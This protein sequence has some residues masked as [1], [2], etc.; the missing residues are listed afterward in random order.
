MADSDGD[1]DAPCVLSDSESSDEGYY[2]LSEFE[3]DDPARERAAFENIDAAIEALAVERGLPPVP[4]NK[5]DG[6]EMDGNG[7][8]D[9]EETHAQ[10][11]KR[12]RIMSKRSERKSTARESRS[13]AEEIPKKVHGSGKS[14]ARGARCG[15]TASQVRQLMHF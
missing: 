4:D 15:L 8:M 1:S 12:R 2:D 7:E 3:M 5:L 14:A 11:A 9:G 6:E 13:A 10:P